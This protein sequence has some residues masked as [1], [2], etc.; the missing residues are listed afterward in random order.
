MQQEQPQFYASLA[1]HLSA[2]E[3]TMIQNVFNQAEA[4]LVIAQQQ[5]AAAGAAIDPASSGGAAAN[6]GAS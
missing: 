2:E 5:A 6:G 4:Q 1:S 3:Q